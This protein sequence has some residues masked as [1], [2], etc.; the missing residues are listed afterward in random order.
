[1]VLTATPL[2]AKLAI[3][4]SVLELVETSCKLP[5]MNDYMTSLFCQE[6]DIDMLIAKW[7][8]GLHN[9]YEFLLQYMHVA[10]M[11]GVLE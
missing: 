7:F 8:V 10:N 4:S 2:S 5:A 1:M 6:F 11:G 3:S 9:L